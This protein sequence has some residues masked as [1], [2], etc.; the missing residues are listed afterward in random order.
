M[1]NPSITITSADK[2]HPGPWYGVKR[3]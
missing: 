3:F 2:V 1:V